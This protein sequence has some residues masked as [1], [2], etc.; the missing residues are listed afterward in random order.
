MCGIH[1]VTVI[2]SGVSMWP[3]L[4]WS[5]QREVEF[6]SSIVRG[7]TVLYSTDLN[8]EVH[9]PYCSWL[10]WPWKTNFRLKQ[11]EWQKESWSLMML[12]ATGYIN[13]NICST[14]EL[15][16]IG[17]VIFFCVCVSCLESDFCYF[18]QIHINKYIKNRNSI[19]QGPEVGKS[20]DN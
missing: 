2:G 15:P 10:L 4:S 18:G 5:D 9:S 20:W 8:K 12:L 13:C 3:K 1:L 6:F 14:S 7:G 11:S 16:A 19:C 17:T